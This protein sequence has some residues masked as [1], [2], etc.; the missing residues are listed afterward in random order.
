MKSCL[1]TLSLFLALAVPQLK[2]DPFYV[3]PVKGDDT[4]AGSKDAPF[5]TIAR[6]MKA[7]SF[8]GF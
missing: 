5:K 4:A 2:A 7:L 8:R 3:D 6:A 1:V